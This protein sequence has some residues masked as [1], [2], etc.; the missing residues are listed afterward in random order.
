MGVDGT[1][2]A[3]QDVAF[4]WRC[5]N[6]GGRSGAPNMDTLFNGLGDPYGS[7]CAIEI[8]VPVALATS[9]SVPHVRV[10]TSG[11]MVQVFS[12][13][14]GVSFDGTYAY[15]TIAGSIPPLTFN[16]AVQFTI[17]GTGVAGLD[18]IWLAP[19]LDWNYVGGVW[20]VR[21]P[22]TLTGGPYTGL[23][24]MIEYPAGTSRPPWVLLDFLL[25]C[26]WDIADINMPSFM[27]ADAACG[28]P[29]SYADQN[30]NTQTKDRYKYQ[31]VL[32][33]RRS[34]AQATR[35]MLGSMNGVAVPNSGGAL[36]LVVK[37]TLADQQP[38]LPDGS[39]YSTAVASV[40]ADGTAGN[41]YVAYAFDESNI[42]RDN[43]G[44]GKP[45]FN[46]VQRSNPDL[47]ALVTVNW[48]DEDNQYVVDSLT[49]ADLPAL[50]RVSQNT[51]AAPPAEGFANYDQV[52]RIVNTWFAEN[53][54]GNPRND[55]GGTFQVQITTTF[56]G[57]KL[58]IGQIVMLSWAQAGISQ[59][60]FRILQLKPST[61]FETVDLLLQWHEDA[62]YTNAYGQA[63]TPGG[64][65]S[66]SMLP[67]RPP[68]PIMIGEC[69]DAINPLHPGANSRL[70][71]YSST[72][73]YSLAPQERIFGIQGLLPVNTFSQNTRP[74]FVPAQATTSSTGGSMAGGQTVWCA[75]AAEDASGAVTPL[76]SFVSC[77]IPA[78]T[79]TNTV[80]VSGIQWAPGTVA[81][82][83]WMGS[84]PQTL[85]YAGQQRLRAGRF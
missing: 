52:R 20:I 18:K 36:T 58:Q 71:L 17:S 47:P 15:V 12:G 45:K 9:A 83:A 59:Q 13:V 74:P 62:W 65:G 84:S 42:I 77:Y 3:V 32:R 73:W 79:N 53:A 80:A 16:Q 44:R 70:A 85:F 76:S 21:F 46:I 31:N 10:E 67:M 14:T 63:T 34:A 38:T 30:G 23:G 75:F 5:I 4:C 2:Y 49:L 54:W 39:N 40:H 48:Q 8:V 37:Q 26:G 33:Q 24:G 61:D 50:Q 29:V 82:H 7:Y 69:G 28:V 66:G 43:E 6:N 22:C 51:T 35:G 72:G 41:G 60:L 57:V 81:C 56:K 1:P 68:Y 55:P 19:L 78:G 64:N 27:A 11:P 25:W